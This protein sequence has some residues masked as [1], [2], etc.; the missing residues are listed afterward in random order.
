MLMPC[1]VVAVD[2][3]WVS[4]LKYSIRCLLAAYFLLG[5]HEVTHRSPSAIGF[6][7]FYQDLAVVDLL[8]MTIFD[9]SRALYIS[10]C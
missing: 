1:A 9:A 6:H 8:P 10:T 5:H 7:E 4:Y 3:Y 2:F